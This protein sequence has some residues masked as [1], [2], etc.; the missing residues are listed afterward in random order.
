MEIIVFIFSFTFF[1]CAAI[2]IA[3]FIL[4]KGTPK[5]DYYTVYYTNKTSDYDYN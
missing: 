3:R 2:F 5:N 1:S 4:R